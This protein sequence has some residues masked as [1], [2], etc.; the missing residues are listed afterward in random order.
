MNNNFGRLG[1]FGWVRRGG[2]SGVLP[3]INKIIQWLTGSNGETV[4]DKKS[5]IEW[6]LSFDGVDD[7]LDAPP[8]DVVTVA[9][10]VELCID[11]TVGSV[12][13]HQVIGGA[14]KDPWAST[15]L[16]GIYQ[17]T[18]VLYIFAQDSS[19]IKQIHTGLSVSIGDRLDLHLTYDG[20]T[21]KLVRGTTTIYE[22]NTDLSGD[23]VTSEPV[24][25]HVSFG[26][27]T[28]NYDTTQ[29]FYPATMVL[30]SAGFRGFAE[31]CLDAG[32]GLVAIDSSIL[33]NDGIIEGGATWVSSYSGLSPVSVV[34]V[35]C[36]Y[37][38]GATTKILASHLTGPETVVSSD[39]ASTPSIGVGEIT[40]TAGTCHS[41]ILSDGTIY[42]LEENQG[43]ICYDS[44]GNGNHGTLTT[45][46]LASARTT[47]D[48]IK[49]KS[50]VDG[51]TKGATMLDAD[52]SSNDDGWYESR[53]KTTAGV[54][55]AGRDDCL[56]IDMFGGAGSKY[57][58]KNVGER[59]PDSHVR[60]SLEYFIPSNQPLPNLGFKLH[61]A[62][63][64]GADI[65]GTLQEEDVWTSV[66]YDFVSPVT[67]TDRL[68]IQPLYTSDILL[69]D[70]WVMYARNFK[71][72]ETETQVPALEDGTGGADGYPITNP[73]GYIANGAVCKYVQTDPSLLARGDGFWVVGGAFVRRD[74]A[75][76]L[77]R[78]NLTQDQI[79]KWVVDGVCCLKESA[80]YQEGTVDGMKPY[81]FKK[82]VA[83]IGD[84]GC[85]AGTIEPVTMDGEYVTVDGSIVLP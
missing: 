7:K 3:L 40:F 63:S 8:I 62:G 45:A 47:M 49:C 75:D 54:T 4:T 35:P 13:G 69:E 27:G 71:I 53:C 60:V 29:I 2:A 81:E 51:F 38:D 80:L 36:L 16:I 65:S 78:T 46:D 6:G 57:T 21:L 5:P 20:T 56:K 58:H 55:H 59:T 32:D 73:G 68:N 11:Y 67:S 85:G 18:N 52:W 76:W 22:S 42:N 24:H 1:V 77:A 39:G 19:G 43:T 17:S 9:Q 37:F 61:D 15:G 72:I 66:T 31:Y 44:S 33:G 82:A 74:W 12:V 48:G 30:H 10:D 41:L 25:Q 34:D 28:V 70:Q 83:W 64:P 14:M 26:G 23:L 50:L 79:D 84:S